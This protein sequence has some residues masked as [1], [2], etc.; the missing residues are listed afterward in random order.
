MR[1]LPN[2]DVEASVGDADDIDE[3]GAGVEENFLN[4][5][6]DLTITN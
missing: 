3:I 5:I 6:L 2:V 1:D 4:V